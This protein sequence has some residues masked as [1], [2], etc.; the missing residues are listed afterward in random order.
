MEVSTFFSR[1]LQ[2]PK[3]A[4]STD[5]PAS[6]AAFD[7]AWT[8]VRSTLEHPDERQLA[9]GIG[10]TD[11]PKNLKLIVDALVYES[12]RTD[13]DTTGACLEYFLRHDMLG[14]LE[15]L[16]QTNRPRGIKREWVRKGH[17]DKLGVAAD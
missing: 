2:A 15:R 4:A 14:Q 1:L 5:D 9:R 10:S 7:A 17:R 8:S 13:E 12:N 3:Q 16:C 6:L 11:V